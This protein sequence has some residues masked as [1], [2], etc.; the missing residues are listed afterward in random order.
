MQVTV[1]DGLVDEVE[2]QLARRV[3]DLI[4]CTQGGRAVAGYEKVKSWLPNE[5][6]QVLIQ[7]STGRSAA[8]RNLARRTTAS[9]LVG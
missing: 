8:K 4:A 3:V 6:A 5:E 9:I 7:A 1:P 2:K